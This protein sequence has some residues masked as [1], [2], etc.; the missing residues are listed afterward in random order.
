M[1][2]L[3]VLALFVSVSV[4]LPVIA[5]AAPTKKPDM[6][7]VRKEIDLTLHADTGFTKDQRVAIDRAAD[8]WKKLSSGRVRIV[9]AYDL[10]FSSASNLR[11]HKAAKHSM[12][13]SIPSS[14]PLVQAA[15]DIIADRSGHPRGSIAVEAFTFAPPSSPV[16]MI[17]IVAD[18]VS[19]QKYRQVVQHEMGHGIGLDDLPSV[20]KD[21]MSGADLPGSHAGEFTD[22]DRALCRTARYCD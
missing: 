17:W 8:E 13:I 20:A 9:I 18:R 7:L 6:V 22:A 19:P 5:D 3:A 16:V 14:A 11:E 15:D 1:R 10:D 2:L 12:M 21:I 4:L